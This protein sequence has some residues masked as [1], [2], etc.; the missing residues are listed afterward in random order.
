MASPFRTG[1]GSKADASGTHQPIVRRLKQHM[2]HNC[3]GSGVPVTARRVEMIRILQA[4]VDKLLEEDGDAIGDR[5]TFGAE[6]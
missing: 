4:A 3:L 2:E 5:P 6:V 1:F